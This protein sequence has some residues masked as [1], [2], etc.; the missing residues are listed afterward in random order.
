MASKRFTK[1]S[2]TGSEGGLLTSADQHDPILVLPYDTVVEVFNYVA[3]YHLVNVCRLVSKTWK[4]FFDDPSYWR[5]RIVNESGTFNPKLNEIPVHT[6]N[7]P[8]LYI[9]TAWK[10]NLIRS[11]NA[12]G[13]LSLEFWTKSYQSW[14]AISGR[15]LN[16]ASKGDSVKAFL[17]YSGHRE[18][19]YGGG[20]RW[21]IESNI[22]QNHP[23]NK[24]LMVDNN[25]STQNY[26]TSYQWC[27]REQVIT[28]ANHGFMDDIMDIVQPT[29]FVSEWFC[30]RW[31]CGSIFN[32][33][34]EL[35]GLKGT[36]IDSFEESV[37]TSQWEGGELGWR[38]VEHTFSDYGPGVRYVRFVDGGKDTKV[39]AGHYGSKMAGAQL[40]VNFS[41]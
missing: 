35:V 28:L 10:P 31:D 4:G 32:V 24:Q 40:R 21:S 30:A 18:G 38:R 1:K 33:R 29:I 7:W 6:V 37:T 36:V 9:N 20:N 14:E 17:D 23:Q 19:D 27:C 5:L 12:D 15:L 13:E 2:S 22:N 8:L 39:W 34:V 16:N 11:F 3:P 25:K 26:V 41:K